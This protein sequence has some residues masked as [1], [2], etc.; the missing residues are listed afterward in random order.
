[1]NED[2][3]LN[4]SWNPSTDNVASLIILFIELMMRN[5]HGIGEGPSE[6]VEIETADFDTD[7]DLLT[8]ARMMGRFMAIPWTMIM[9]TFSSD[10]G[11]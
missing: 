7:G 9:I 10:N 11:L 2:G 5:L 4:L 3:D 8:Q 1:M 6:P